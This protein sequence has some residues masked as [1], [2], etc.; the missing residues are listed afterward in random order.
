MNLFPHEITERFL[1]AFERLA[2]GVVRIAVALERANR[3]PKVRTK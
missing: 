1:A 3:L 2:D